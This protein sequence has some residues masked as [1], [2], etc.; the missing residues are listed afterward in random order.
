MK[1]FIDETLIRLLSTCSF[2]ILLGFTRFCM[3]NVHIG[4]HLHDLQVGPFRIDKEKGTV[5]DNLPCCNR[6]NQYIEIQLGITAYDG[7]HV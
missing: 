4:F 3:A 6:Q 1:S 5:V 2:L 7:G